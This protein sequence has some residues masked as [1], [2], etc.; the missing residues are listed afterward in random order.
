MSAA[1]IE[2]AAAAGHAWFQEQRRW[3]EFWDDHIL[4]GVDGDGHQL[5]REELTYAIRTYGVPAGSAAAEYVIR[6]INGQIRP[7]AHRPT[8]E[9]RGERPPAW[10]IVARYE[11]RLGQLQELR[12]DNPRVYRKQFGGASPSS[13]A[14]QMI[15]DEIP[16]VESLKTLEKILASARRTPKPR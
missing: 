13:V 12:Q 6:W 15:V 1:E 5:T 8:L 2:R 11:S 9:S 7:P 3:A 10:Q 4:R 16:K 14:R